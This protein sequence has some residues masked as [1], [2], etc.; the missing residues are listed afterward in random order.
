[1][2]KIISVF[3]ESDYLDYSIIML[4]LI[5]GMY[6]NY[7][8]NYIIM[9]AFVIWFILRPIYVNNLIKLC[10]STIIL[11]PFAQIAKNTD[12]AESLGIFVY[13]LVVLIIYQIISSQ[14][15]ADD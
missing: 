11:I 1:M 12:I 10:L 4:T 14:N 7:H 5:L 2:K 3:I 6:L 13:I 8:T 15:K 9:F